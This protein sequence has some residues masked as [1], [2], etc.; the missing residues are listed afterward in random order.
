MSTHSMS[1]SDVQV[2]EALRSI[3]GPVFA[4]VWSDN[5]QTRELTVHASAVR[6]QRDLKLNIINMLSNIGN[7]QVKV[8][9]PRSASKRD[10][11]SPCVVAGAAWAALQTQRITNKTLTKRIA[12]VYRS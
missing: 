9:I 3:A 2:A 10:M 1:A 7:E 6:G 11:S 12:P 4:A 8:S 5:R